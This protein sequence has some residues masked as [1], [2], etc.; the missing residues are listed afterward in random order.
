MGN[1]L[2]ERDAMPPEKRRFTRI[3]IKLRSTL[4]IEGRPVLVSES[5]LN[6]SIG[7][8]L[9]PASVVFETGT[10]CQVEMALSGSNQSVTIYVDGELTRVDED[11]TAVRF[12][13][14]DPDSLFHLQNV[15][16]YN[17][18]DV[19]TVEAEIGQRPGIV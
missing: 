13:R 8:C 11:E 17:T 1:P 4:Y 14:I 16:R 5:L 19:D 15:I 7:G 18:E 12:T 9:L 3:P 6:L 10:S 2:Q